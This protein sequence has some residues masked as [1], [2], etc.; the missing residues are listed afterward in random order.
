MP[1]SGE[2]LSRGFAWWRI[3]EVVWVEEGAVSRVTWSL[4]E[5]STC[6]SSRDSGDTPNQRNLFFK[7]WN[8]ESS[9]M[10]LAHLTAGQSVRAFRLPLKAEVRKML[11]SGKDGIN[12]FPDRAASGDKRKHGLLFSKGIV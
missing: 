7:A 2:G 10:T 3:I 5:G 8:L 11:E 6:N 1:P 9:F 4:E 12:P